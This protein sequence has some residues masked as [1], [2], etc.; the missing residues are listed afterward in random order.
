[1]IDSSDGQ[2]K[3]IPLIPRSVA[4]F[5]REFMACLRAM[6]VDIHL[7]KRPVEVSEGITFDRDE[8]ARLVR[9]RVCH[10]ILAYPA[11]DAAGV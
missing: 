6:D 10:A 9:C 4:E 8:A 2:R 5:Y 11:P 7:W 1:M 3:V